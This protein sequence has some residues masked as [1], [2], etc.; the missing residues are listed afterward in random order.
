MEN[1]KYNSKTNQ[2]FSD[3]DLIQKNYTNNLKIKSSDRFM[4][5]KKTHEVDEMSYLIAKLCKYLSIENVRKNK[6]N[7]FAL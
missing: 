6:V 1:L 2:E 5:E 4:T 7:Y 3:F